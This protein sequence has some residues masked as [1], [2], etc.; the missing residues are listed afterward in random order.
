VRNS[1]HFVAAACI[2]VGGDSAGMEF[3][4]NKVIVPKTNI[5]SH[6]SRTAALLFVLVLATFAPEVRLA[7]QAEDPAVAEF[8]RAVAAYLLLHQ[9]LAGEAPPLVPGSQA[10]QVS[11]SSDVLAGAIQRARRKARQ[12]DLFT[13]AVS[14]VFTERLR[15]AVD[16]DTFKRM[17]A[18]LTDEPI[19]TRN[20]RV[21]MRSPEASPL[22]TMPAHVLLVLPVLPEELEYRFIRGDLI[23]RDRHAALI[24]DYIPGVLRK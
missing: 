12:G 17:Q 23:L 21:H 7:G 4:R 1:R 19:G 3:A 13:P 22:A 5:T 18:T 16:A 10:S 2:Q 11:A 20:P 14:R 24:I 8:Q 9:R 15:A 6:L